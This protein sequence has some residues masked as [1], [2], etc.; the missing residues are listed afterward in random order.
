MLMTLNYNHYYAYS[1]K[2]IANF[3]LSLIEEG[4]NVQI[5]IKAISYYSS[6]QL[7]IFLSLYP[8]FYYWQ[9]ILT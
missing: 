7:S 8:V 4:H 6:N 3:L 9:Y 2:L 5:D 1:I